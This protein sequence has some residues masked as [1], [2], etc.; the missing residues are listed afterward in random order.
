MCCLIFLKA[1]IYL[2]CGGWCWAN[3]TVCMWRSED[4]PLDLVL[5]LQPGRSSELNPGPQAWQ[6]TPLPAEMY[7]FIRRSFSLVNVCA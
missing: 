5:S 1:C 6:Q 7:C 4:D 3:D 2:F